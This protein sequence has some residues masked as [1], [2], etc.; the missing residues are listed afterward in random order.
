M[1]LGTSCTASAELQLDLIDKKRPDDDWSIVEIVS[2]IEMCFCELPINEKC[3][4]QLPI[5]V[6]ASV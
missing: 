3:S 1:L 2:R 4:V 6:L 5:Y